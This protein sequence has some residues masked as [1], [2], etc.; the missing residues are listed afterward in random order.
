MPRKFKT[1][2][3]PSLGGKRFPMNTRTTAQTRRL[4]VRAARKSGRSL[5]QELEWRLEQS[6]LQERLFEEL[7]EI[8]R[9]IG[10]AATAQAAE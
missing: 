8:K 10:G 4:I 5:A 6:F 2:V 7:A 9:L 1:A 3:D